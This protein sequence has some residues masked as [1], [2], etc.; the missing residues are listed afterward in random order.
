M[1]INYAKALLLSYPHIEQLIEQIDDLVLKKALAAFSDFSPCSEIAE[2]ILV[3]TEKKD[4]LLKIKVTNDEIL[5]KLT[6]EEKDLLDYKYFKIKP[7][8]YYIDFDYTSRNYFRRQSKVVKRVSSLFTE[9]GL[10]DE[11]FEENC[12]PTRFFSNLIK[13]VVNHEQSMQKNKSKKSKSINKDCML[14]KEIS[15]KLSA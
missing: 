1:N 4:V 11:W 5:S 6:E 12:L 14:M 9:R 10:D 13:R 15:L 7:K 8:E 3:L 2:K